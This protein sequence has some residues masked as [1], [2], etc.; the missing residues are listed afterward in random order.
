MQERVY[1]RIISLFTLF[2]V[3]IL[4]FLV[5]IVSL[6]YRKTK[7]LYKQFRTVKTIVVYTNKKQQNEEK[8]K[9]I[10]KNID[11]TDSFLD[12]IDA[13]TDESYVPENYI[14]VK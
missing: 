4:L 11:D 1:Y 13:V 7:Q 5:V 14:E 10:L 8:V 2:S 3:S 9:D 6:E 12:A